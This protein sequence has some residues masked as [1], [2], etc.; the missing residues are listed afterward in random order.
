MS[1]FVEFYCVA[2][3]PP[4]LIPSIGDSLLERLAGS[5]TKKTSAAPICLIWHSLMIYLKKV[6]MTEKSPKNC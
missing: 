6:S 5:I 3:L 2:Q 4:N 1:D